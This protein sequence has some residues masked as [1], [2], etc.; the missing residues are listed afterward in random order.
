[1]KS[2]RLFVLMVLSISLGTSAA[3]VSQK[4]VDVA[5]RYFASK[6]GIGIVKG[7]LSSARNA[8]GKILKL[9]KT[10]SSADFYAYN[11]A[12]GGFVLMAA[13][14]D[15]VNVIGYSLDANISFDNLPDALAEWLTS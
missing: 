11:V 8:S 15:D 1:M 7:E 13:W 9:K 14:N 3:N 4:A 5:E 6:K 12:D 10:A 2:L